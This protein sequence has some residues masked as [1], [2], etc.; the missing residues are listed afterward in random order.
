MQGHPRDIKGEANASD[1]SANLLGTFVVAGG[2]EVRRGKGDEG[3]FPA[4]YFVKD[5]PVTS[6]YFNHRAFVYIEDVRRSADET[7]ERLEDSRVYG[8]DASLDDNGVYLL[9]LKQ[10]MAADSG[11]RLLQTPQEPDRV[12]A[13]AGL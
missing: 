12:G 3:R 1:E 7:R 4:L 9:R 5:H 10:A 2:Q 6:N 11:P 13:A 8:S